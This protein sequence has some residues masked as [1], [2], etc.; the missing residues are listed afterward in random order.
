MRRGGET[1]AGAAGILDFCP[2]CLLTDRGGGGGR[3]G[4]RGGSSAG[5]GAAEGGKRD[6]GCPEEDGKR[7]GFGDGIGCVV[8]KQLRPLPEIGT[9]FVVHLGNK[10]TRISRAIGSGVERID[11]KA[12]VDQFSAN[13]RLYDTGD[14]KGECVPE[15]NEAIVA[16]TALLVSMAGRGASAPDADAG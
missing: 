6:G 11:S 5:A 7:G 15:V 2:P 10:R 9:V 1:K 12:V 13:P 14:I 4:R 16:L 3:M 8:D